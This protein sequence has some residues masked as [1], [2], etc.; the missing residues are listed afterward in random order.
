MQSTSSLV[1]SYYE[2]DR[3]S[4]PEE[5][6]TDVQ[7]EPLRQAK[8]ERS[9]L[10]LSWRCERWVD[11]THVVEGSMEELEHPMYRDAGWG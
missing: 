1:L 9:T 10:D 8:K 3:A 5:E 4:N 6:S 7:G 11:L 2:A